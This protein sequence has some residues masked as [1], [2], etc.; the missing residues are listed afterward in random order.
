MSAPPSPG[1]SCVLSLDEISGVPP[2]RLLI[3]NLEHADYAFYAGSG[4]LPEP[5]VF[6]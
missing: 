4:V 6:D 3:T 5:A 1:G 2:V